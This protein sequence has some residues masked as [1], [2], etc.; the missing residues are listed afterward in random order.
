MCVC[1]PLVCIYHILYTMDVRLIEV[2][3]K[4]F[5]QKEGEIAKETEWTWLGR[6]TSLRG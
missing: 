4:V 3:M 6:L 1:A 2:L 5:I